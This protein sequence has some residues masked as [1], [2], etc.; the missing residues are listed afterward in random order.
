MNNMSTLARFSLFPLFAN[1][2]FKPRSP[3]LSLDAGHPRPFDW[4]WS[5][6][7]SKI[8]YWLREIDSVIQGF[9]NGFGLDPCPP[10]AGVVFVN[11][12]VAP[13]AK[14]HKILIR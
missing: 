1:Q 10:T 6:H 5:V 12:G 8:D 11:Y 2:F 9:E 3:S 13:I 7:T 4:V 14:R